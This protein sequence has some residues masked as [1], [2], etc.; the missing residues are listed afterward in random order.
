M[1]VANNSIQK[2]KQKKRESIELLWQC[3]WC[4][5][6]LTKNTS[7]NVSIFFFSFSAVSSR[8]LEKDQKITMY[9]CVNRREKL[10][11]K[12]ASE[13]IVT[14]NNSME[15]TTTTNKKKAKTIRQLHRMAE[16]TTII[17]I[18]CG[19]REKKKDLQRERAGNRYVVSVHYD[20][21]HIFNTRSTL[22]SQWRMHIQQQQQQKK[23]WKRAEH[24]IYMN[25]AHA[26]YTSAH[27]HSHTCSRMA[28]V[29]HNIDYF[30]LLIFRFIGNYIRCVP[31]SLSFTNTHSEK[32][33]TSTEMFRIRRTE[34]VMIFF[35]ELFKWSNTQYNNNSICRKTRS[36]NIKCKWKLVWRRCC[37]N[38]ISHIN[39]LFWPNAVTNEKH[40]H[41]H[42]S[43]LK[44][45]FNY[46]ADSFEHNS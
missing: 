34:H 46:S 44:I 24:K 35:P 32:S 21:K 23:N 43:W 3:R 25:R 7:S 2:E 39:K 14:Y 40:T 29:A 13:H 30:S 27:T 4:A 16:K 1:I 10:F 28:T 37:K 20:L 41:T 38:K 33:K 45:N 18:V 19:E 31:L 12:T 42:T 26:T 11:R 15:I 36:R 17:T 8:I 5:R 9:T 22:R 6:A